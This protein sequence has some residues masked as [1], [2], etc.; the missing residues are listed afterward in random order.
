MMIKKV[1]CLFSALLLLFALPGCS[2]PTGNLGKKTETGTNKSTLTPV[3]LTFYIAG[4]GEKN[5]SKEVFD[6]VAEECGLNIKL[7]FKYFEGKYAGPYLQEIKKVIASNAAFDALCVGMPEEYDLSGGGYSFA[8]M[9]RDGVLKDI[10]GLLP[11]YAPDILSMLDKKELEAAK[12]DGKLYAI[13]SLY[14]RA[15]NVFAAVNQDLMNKYG[16]ETLDTFEDYGNYLKAVK[17]NEPDVLPG[18]LDVVRWDVKMLNDAMF[19]IPYGYVPVD[20][21]LK[22]AVKRDDPDMNIVPWEQTEAFKNV[23]IM[24]SDWQNKGYI[25][26]LNSGGGSDRPIASYLGFGSVLKQGP[27]QI[28]DGDNGRTYDFYGYPLYR[29]VKV[30]RGSPVDNV[31]SSPAIALNAKSENAERALMFLNWVQS[32]QENYDL[33]VY[34]IKGSQ[35]TLEGERLVFPEETAADYSSYRYWSS[36]PFRNV[37]YIRLSADD[38]NFAGDYRR[39][40]LEF[41]DSQTVYAPNTGFYPDYRQQLAEEARKRLN[42]YQELITFPFADGSFDPGKM[43]SII[44]QLKEA[45]TDRLIAGLQSQLDGWRGK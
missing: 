43:D 38:K 6:K 1:L 10:T 5:D 21:V 18:K 33:L 36:A 30:P 12:I 37:K 2:D 35:Y 25:A 13:P 45:G 29:E 9:A 3:T 44:P 31:Y 8:D 23:M 42:R 39:E 4:G 40:Y 20:K 28:T 26:R 27:I 14:P 24:L 15:E 22:L 41:I 11:E 17:E 19:M 7:E 32:S 16:I 34:G